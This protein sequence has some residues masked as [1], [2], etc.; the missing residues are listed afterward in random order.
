MSSPVEAPP[1]LALVARREG[2]GIR[3]Q[4][5]RRK[6]WGGQREG[7]REREGGGGG[8]GGR[9]GGGG[10]GGGGDFIPSLFVVYHESH[11]MIMQLPTSCSGLGLQ[12]H[13]NCVYAGTDLTYGLCGKDQGSQS[14]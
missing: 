7:E 12:L 8:G 11:S 4:E 9:G 6:R 10:G 14:D 13:S 1:R 3:G 5:K 2:E